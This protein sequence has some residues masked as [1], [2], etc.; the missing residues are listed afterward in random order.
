MILLGNNVE[1]HTYYKTV[2]VCIN[3]GKCGK[4]ALKTPQNTP[5]SLSNT[6]IVHVHNI[7]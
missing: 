7:Y 1:S 3:D 6:H 2:C 5:F 4:A